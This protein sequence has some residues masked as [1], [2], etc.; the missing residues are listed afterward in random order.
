MIPIQEL[1]SQNSLDKLHIQIL[2]AIHIQLRRNTLIVITLVML[3]G[4]VLI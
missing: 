1:Y 2:K 3:L 4:L